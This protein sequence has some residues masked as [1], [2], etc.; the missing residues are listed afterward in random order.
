ML[1][2]DLVCLSFCIV[3]SKPLKS[4]MVPYH[5]MYFCDVVVGVHLFPATVEFYG[6]V[7]VFHMFIVTIGSNALLPCDVIT[8]P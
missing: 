4:M 1:K 5:E 7:Q 2:I 8:K 6:S 3:S